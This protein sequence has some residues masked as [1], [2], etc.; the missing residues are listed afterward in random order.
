MKFCSKCGN[1]LLDEAVMCPK[2]GCPV[3]EKNSLKKQNNDS[4][5]K[6]VGVILILISLTIIIGLIYTVASA[7][8]Y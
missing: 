3:N 5:R 4:L 1:E 2:C 7:L 8:A 6:V